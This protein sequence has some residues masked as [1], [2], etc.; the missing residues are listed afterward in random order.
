MLILWLLYMLVNWFHV[1]E[2]LLCKKLRLCI[3]RKLDAKLATYVFLGYSPSQWGYLCLEKVIGKVSTSW[4]VVFAKSMFPYLFAQYTYS[5][6][7]SFPMSSFGHFSFLYHVF[8]ILNLIVR[9]HLQLWVCLF[10]F[11]FCSLSHIVLIF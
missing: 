3:N 11:G 2:D 10:Y 9:S 6:V 4:H 8:L 7:T 1:Q 5:N